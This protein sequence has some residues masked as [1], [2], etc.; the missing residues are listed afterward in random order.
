[1]RTRF[2][3]TCVAST[4]SVLVGVG[5]F[6]PTASAATPAPQGGTPVTRSGGAGFYLALGDSVAVGYEPGK[7]QNTNHGYVDDLWRSV[8]RRIPGLALRNLACVGRRLP[9]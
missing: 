3:K 6:L 7:G 2:L 8:R 5:L 1:M 9:R 4:L